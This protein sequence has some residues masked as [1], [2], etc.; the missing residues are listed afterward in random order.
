MMVEIILLLGDLIIISVVAL[1]PYFQKYSAN[2]TKYNAEKLK[3][4]LTFVKMMILFPMALYMLI[5]L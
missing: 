4:A 1:L 5:K 3:K 2:Y